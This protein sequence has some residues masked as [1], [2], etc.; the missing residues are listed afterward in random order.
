MAANIAD[1]TLALCGIAQAAAVVSD[2]AENG[3]YDQAAMATL[4]DSLFVFEP[5]NTEAVYGSALALSLGKRILRAVFTA[6]P[7]SQS[8]AAMAYVNGIITLEKQLSRQPAL[9]DVIRQRLE[10][11]AT[12][13]TTLYDSDD[14]YFSAI[15]GVYTDTVSTLNYRL[16]VTGSPQQLQIPNNADKIRTALLAGIRSAMLWRQLGGRRWRLLFQRR[17]TLQEL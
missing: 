16:K 5:D 12:Q 6:T 3:R 10:T 1:Q 4:C 11:I 13:K 17:R 15:A 7:T 2:I 9:L 8:Q 14:A